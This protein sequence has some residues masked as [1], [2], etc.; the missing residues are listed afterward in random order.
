MEKTLNG[1]DK[2]AATVKKASWKASILRGLLFALAVI[3]F[4]YGFKVTKVSFE[5]INSPTRQ[6]SLTRVLCAIAKPD[7]VE[8]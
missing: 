7:L 1:S 8:Y 3:I 6:E 2:P 4:A 5:Q